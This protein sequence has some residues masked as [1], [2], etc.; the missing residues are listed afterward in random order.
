MK[1]LPRHLLRDPLFLCGLAVKLGLVALVVPQLQTQWFVAFLQAAVSAP[2]LD[3]WSAWMAAGGDAMAFPYGAVMM[4]VTLPGTAVGAGLDALLGTAGLTGLGFRLN[5]LALDVALLVV[6]TR[7]LR[8]D[9]GGVLRY[10]WLSP[11]AVFITYWHGQLDLVP[12]LFLSL[13]LLLLRGQRPAAAGA[14]IGLAVGAKFSVLIAAPFLYV[15]LL[16]NKRLRAQAA[17]FTNAAGLAMLALYLPALASPGF[18]RMA[19]QTPEAAKIYLLGLGIA[20]GLTVYGVPLVYAL[21][22]YAV[23]RFRRISLDLLMAMTGLS[24]FVV[25]LLTPASVGWYLWVLP[26]LV[27]YQLRGDANTNLLMLTFS[28]ALVGFHGVVSAGA[29]LPLFGVRTVTLAELFTAP[30]SPH[31]KSLM[32]TVITALG[33]VLATRLYRDGVRR[34]SFAALALRPLAIGIAG[35]SGAGKD[36]LSEALANLFGGHSVAHL[37]GDNYHLWDRHAPMWKAVTHLDP[38]AND[39]PRFFADAEALIHGASIASP[40]YDHRAGRFHGLVGVSRNDI[41]IVTGL[42]TLFYEPFSDLL[43]IRIFLEIDEGLRRYWKIRRDVLERQ[44]SIEQVLESLERRKQDAA[45]Y[46]EPQRRRA[47]IVF[48]LMPVNPELVA[49]PLAG[50]G[51]ALRLKLKATIRNG[52]YYNHLARALIGTCAM[53][54]DV[55]VLDDWSVEM[56][57]EGDLTPDDAAMAARLLVPNAEEILDVRPR[58]GDQTTGVMQLIVLMHVSAVLSR[59][60][61]K[62]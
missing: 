18:Q 28:L 50:D 20:E 51:R 60:A 57:V 48:A 40:H 22:L 2:S 4:A 61:L 45:R 14:V 33:V 10:Y 19:L 1:T 32:L 9:V 24:F 30:P 31:L 11:L 26:F 8:D 54:L 53:Q 16:R 49:D 59:R 27:A 62:E 39:L 58:W 38:R 13:S 44:H 7:L 21:L 15:Y 23:T 52:L 43:D 35:D 42:H 12:V 56:L 29:A 41:V 34:N 46:V 37:S 25:L 5:L 6:L 17:P 3:P 36:T 55:R 47:D